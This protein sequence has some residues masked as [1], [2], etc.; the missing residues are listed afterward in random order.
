MGCKYWFVDSKIIVPGSAEKGFEGC[1]Y[2]RSMRSHKEAFAAIVQINEDSHTKK[3]DLLLLSKLMELQKSPLP[4]L[5]KEI[6]KLD[7]FKDLLCQ[8]RVLNLK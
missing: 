2:F 5:V 7:A 1:H 3:N 6:M 8:Q 4:A